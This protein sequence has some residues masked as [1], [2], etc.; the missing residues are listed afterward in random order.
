LDVTDVAGPALGRIKGAAFRDF[1]IWY[2]GKRPGASE[3]I[4][5][6]IPQ[7]VRSSL[8][9]SRPALGVIASVWYPVSVVH[10]VLDAVSKDLSPAERVRL[11]NEGAAAIMNA[12]LRGLYKTLF[13]WM[14]TPSRYARFAGKLWSAYYDS[15]E[16]R[17]EMP[18]DKTA[19][20]SITGWTG[21]HPFACDLNRGAA[22][23]IYPAMGCKD[24]QVERPLCVSAGAPICRF[25]TTWRE[26][27]R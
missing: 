15:G 20:C 16:F 14:A 19:I 8:D 26:S 6:K 1:L 12:H 23:T 4:L 9:P 11:S 27:P 2:T 18:D 7:A 5:S 24:V 21:H 17:I 25:V 10:S 22:L 13:E 3:E